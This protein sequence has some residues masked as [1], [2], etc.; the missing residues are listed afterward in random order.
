M[1]INGDASLESNLVA[2]RSDFRVATFE[3][4]LSGVAGQL[5]RFL[6]QNQAYCA[7]GEGLRLGKANNLG[8]L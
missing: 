6:R 2:L 3:P 7:R 5:Q 1:V 4:P 8:K